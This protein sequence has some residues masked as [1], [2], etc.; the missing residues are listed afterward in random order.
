MEEY[1]ITHWNALSDLKR[2]YEIRNRQ[3]CGSKESIDIL[4]AIIS[5]ADHMEAR[6]RNRDAL[7]KEPLQKFKASYIFFVGMN[8]NLST[9]IKGE[10]NKYEDVVQ[11]AF[12]DNY[13]NMTLK[14]SLVLHWIVLYCSQVKYVI[15]MDDDLIYNLTKVFHYM[16]N[17][18]IPP[19]GLIIGNKAKSPARP[20]RDPQNTWYVSEKEYPPREFPDFVYG[21]AYIFSGNT[22][23]RL[24]EA[25]FRVPFLW[26]EDVYIAG[27]CREASG[28]RL[29]VPDFP[30]FCRG[31]NA[32]FLM[33]TKGC[34]FVHSY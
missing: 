7:S 6:Q 3:F 17:V 2:K 4:I 13:K 31:K 34:P 14:S 11:G 20:H 1:A 12:V 30:L 21:G 5:S 27:F 28:V 26:L 23:K 19:S 10:S 18:K 16:S 32:A 29:E 9:T 24:W 33:K 8:T 22:A 15:K 25:T